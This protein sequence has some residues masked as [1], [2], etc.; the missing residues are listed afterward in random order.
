MIFG[1][2]YIECVSC[3]RKIEGKFELAADGNIV[4]VEVSNGAQ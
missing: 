4:Q 1:E 3:E 2:L